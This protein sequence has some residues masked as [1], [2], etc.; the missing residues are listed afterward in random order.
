MYILDIFLYSDIKKLYF[1]LSYYIRFFVKK[2]IWIRGHPNLSTFFTR[3]QKYN[4]L[5]I[6]SVWLRIIK[7]VS[8]MN[9]TILYSHS[10]LLDHVMASTQGRLVSHVGQVRVVEPDLR[11]NCIDKD[12][13]WK[14]QGKY[15]KAMWI[16]ASPFQ[17]ELSR[18]YQNLPMN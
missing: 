8:P 15:C 3:L 4:V 14:S 11:T 18:S 10:I 7:S 1:E 2:I 16:A 9:L 12:S 5:L 13:T 17:C 6:M